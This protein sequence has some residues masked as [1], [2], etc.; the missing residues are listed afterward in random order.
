[1]LPYSNDFLYD[2][3]QYCSPDTVTYYSNCLAKL[4][5]YFVSLRPGIFSD[6]VQ[7]LREEKISNTSIRTYSRGVKV[8][9][10]WLAKHKYVD[11]DLIDQIKLPRPDARIITPLTS[12]Q[13]AK[14]DSF[15]DVSRQRDYLLIH[16]MLDCGLRLGEVVSLTRDSF[17]FDRRFLK[18]QRTKS[19]KPRVVPVP[20][21]LVLE[22]LHYANVTPGA[23]FPLSSSGAKSM[24]HRLKSKLDMP[25][26]HAHLFRHTFGSSF[27]YYKMGDLERLRLL[28]GHE[29]ITTT[30][31][32]LHIANMYDFEGMDIY[33]I[34][35]CFRR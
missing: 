13:V 18:V 33:K 8:Y 14:L 23:L 24:I 16:L 21:W 30:C 17:D 9:F 35:D 5:S 12:A 31:Q 7:L 6:F 22:M 15:F 34:D 3:G 11:Y 32:Y 25:E 19:V 4:E 1:M 20:E 29:D 10:R 26:L 2:R 28:M 27:V